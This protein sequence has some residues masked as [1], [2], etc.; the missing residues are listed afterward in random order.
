MQEQLSVAHKRLW[1]CA[2]QIEDLATLQ[3]RNR[4][5]RDLHDSLGHALT[6]LNIQLQTAVKLWRLD[7]AQAQ[8]F[9]AQA[10]R[11]GSVAI[12]EVR[13]SVRSLRSE[14]IAEQSLDGLIK[15]LTEDFHQATGVAPATSINISTLVPR[16]VATTLY[17]TVQEALT[18]ICKHAAATAVQIQLCDA[19]D[20]VYLTITDNGQGFKLGQCITGF[21]LQGMQERISALGG[22]FHLE[23]QP[24]AGC[25]IAVELPLLQPRL[26]ELEQPKHS[27]LIVPAVA[28]VEAP[29]NS[30][31]SPDLYSR[32]EAMLFDL[33]GPV[34][35]ALL[36]QASV[37]ARSGEELVENLALYLAEHQRVEFESQVTGL[38][39]GLTIPSQVVEPNPQPEEQPDSQA[40]EQPK[41]LSSPMPALVKADVSTDA[42]LSPEQYSDLE[43]ILTELVGP[44]APVLLQ[45]VSAHAYAPQELV[46]NL[47]SYLTLEQRIKLEEKV[48]SL[49]QEPAVPSQIQSVSSLS[50]K[51]P[52]VNES[53][54]GECERSLAD[55]I[56]PIASFLV[57]QIL[58]S[59]PQIS[60][61]ELVETLATEIPD[62]QK[63]N[64]FKQRLLALT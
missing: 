6:A 59:S 36:Q 33:V 41:P 39:Q 30:A 26:Q 22:H 40:K 29:L 34:A 13:Q 62:L 32:L 58:A 48:A 61:I 4:I 42:V 56:G 55:L 24:G 11:L 21:G 20:K 49:L 47:V 45:Q 18:N 60:P 17:R 64:E 43:K 10:Q 8:E 19:E 37:Q 46:E 54:I 51:H 38:L 14:A 28:Q 35:P 52:I 9:L 57:Q 1:Q 2:L 5:A 27:S 7:P 25:Q 16:E 31:A 23:T 50:L 3:E 44:I 53:F 15:S 63:A 12:E